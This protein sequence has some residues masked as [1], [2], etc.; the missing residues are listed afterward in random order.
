MPIFVVLG[1][2]TA[3]G[4]EGIKESRKGNEEV[5][6]LVEAA[7]GKILALYYTFGRYDWVSIVEGPNIETAMKT[8]MMFGMRGGS[9]TETLVAVSDEDTLKII[10]EIP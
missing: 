3:K 6:K 1:N 4:I 2:F 7:G 5:K 8:L 10:D 9:R